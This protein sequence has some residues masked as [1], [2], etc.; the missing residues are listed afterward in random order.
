MAKKKGQKPEGS[1]KK[2]APKKRGNNGNWWIVPVVAAITVA[3]GLLVFAF[4]GERLTGVD[5]K[6]PLPEVKA[7]KKFKEV[8]LYFIGEDGKSLA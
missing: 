1:G 6:S 8:S 3:A 2:P 5:R 4:F 7:V